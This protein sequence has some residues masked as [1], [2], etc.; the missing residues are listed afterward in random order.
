MPA[1]YSKDELVSADEQANKQK[2]LVNLM[3]LCTFQSVCQ[4]MITLQ[5][6]P[7]L[8]RELCNGNVSDAVQVLA[9]T[10]GLVGLLGLF[11][12]QIGGKLSDSIGRKPGLL[13]GPFGN[14]LLGQLVYFNSSN[15]L[16]VLVCRV[17]RMV[18]TT[19][20]NTVMISAALA[21]TCSGKDLAAAASLMGASTGLAVVLTPILEAAILQRFKNA[22]NSYLVLSLLGVVQLLYNSVLMPE[23]LAAVK[24]IPMKAALSI[25][26]FNPLGF[27]RI[28]SVGSQSLQKMTV[29]TSLQMALEGKNMSDISQI[30]MRENLGWSIEGSR[31]FVVGYGTLCVASGVSLTPY[32]LR[33]LSARAFTSFTNFTN[34]FGFILR[35]Q[36]HAACFILAILPMLPGVNGSSA[37]ALQALATDRATSEGFGKGEFSAWS[38]NLRALIGA[39]APVIYGNYYAWARRKGVPPGTVFMLAALLGAVL[40]EML[41]RLITDEEL[42]PVQ[43]GSGMQGASSRPLNT[44][45]K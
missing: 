22:R 8:V 25:K 40:P 2:K 6:E 12:N 18:I 32:L 41:L 38:N 31:N 27:L 35:G 36:E 15:R 1:T 26:N 14:I 39:L 24:K 13:L 44:G 4:H 34:A 11:L 16:L 43:D 20:S 28:F 7:M 33:K 21:D 45:A 30:W 37:R 29:V 5:S 19:F 9:N 23:T 3:F 17:M 10:Q 42:R